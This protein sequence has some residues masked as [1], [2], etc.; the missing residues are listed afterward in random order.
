MMRASYPPSRVL[1]MNM[2]VYMYVHVCV[3]VCV[4]PRV[5]VRVYGWPSTQ[6]GIC[7]LLE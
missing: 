4:R 5:H 7:S 6:L 3:R 2:C 1:N